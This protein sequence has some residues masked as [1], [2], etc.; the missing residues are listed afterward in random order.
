MSAAF[1][2]LSADGPVIED[3]PIDA[4][5]EAGPD[6][7]ACPVNYRVDNAGSLADQL[8]AEVA[9][10]RP[11]AHVSNFVR[12]RVSAKLKRRGWNLVSV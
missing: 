9:R 12:T 8:L 11:W 6:Q 2:L 4:P 5:A 3:Y 7:W 10:L 1:A